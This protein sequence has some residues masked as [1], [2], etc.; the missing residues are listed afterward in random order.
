MSM[1]YRGKLPGTI[2]GLVAAEE[3]EDSSEDGLVQSGLTNVNTSPEPAGHGQDGIPI[4]DRLRAADMLVPGSRLGPN[5][6]DE[7]RRIKRPLLSNA[8]GKSASLVDRG[9]LILVTSSLPGEGKTHTAVNL[10][11]SIAQER[12]H[13]VMLVDCDVEKHGVTRMLGLTGKP[14]LVDLL[15]NSNKTTGDVLLR[16]DVSELTFLCAGKQHGYVT[17]LLASQRMSSLV[18]EMVSRYDDRVIIFDGPPLLPT[19]QTHVLAELVGQ[20]VFVIEAG[21]TA[22][23]VVDEAL[24]MVP[25]DKAIGLVM[26]KTEGMQGHSGYYYGYYGKE[27]SKHK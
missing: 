2:S 15:D 23:D 9:N 10:A 22:Q 16:T 17:E 11:L 26:N 3:S 19:P 21:K 27:G 12:D 18:D 7:Y 24:E 20:V 8:F 5:F 13:T 6:Q 14:G 4:Q 25:K 1:R